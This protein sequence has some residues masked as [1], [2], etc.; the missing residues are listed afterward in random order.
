[1]LRFVIAVSLVLLLTAGTAGQ[2]DTDAETLKR[3]V[4]QLS[5]GDW[6]AREKA[7]KEL[8]LI[9]RP[10][11]EYLRHLVDNPVF[12]V[13]L[14]AKEILNHIR[15]VSVEDAVA[16]KKYLKEFNPSDGA[17][18][19]RDLV[20]KLR[21]LKNVRFYLIE[22][23]AGV[24]PQEREKIASLLACVEYHVEGRRIDKDISYTTDI[25][26]SFARDE[27]LAAQLRL[28]ALRTLSMLKDG[29]A[30]AV[31]ADI[32][33]HE[34][35]NLADQALEGLAAIRGDN[36]KENTTSNKD[37]LLKWWSEASG[38]PAYDKA[39]KHLE[40]RKKSEEKESSR[41]IPFLGVVQ[42]A[43]FPD[44][45]GAYVERPWPD[46]G[47]AKAGIEAGDIIVEFDGRPVACWGDMVHGIRRGLEGQKILLKVL[48][49]GKE[50]EL[51][52]LLSKRPE[53]Q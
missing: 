50:F 42:S 8:V 23:I 18:K 21:R 37:E 52:A 34:T 40:T 2:E 3:L 44:N 38:E 6:R 11:V 13:R 24:R 32:L 25:L 14:R 17:E 4:S 27:L 7:Q 43:A 9:G 10:A 20:I 15:V 46:S 41:E 30:A 36:K 1:M 12:E 51:E 45:G 39:V 33:K 35:G 48:R 19:V 28:R 47:A 5:E 29:D 22:K 49:N 26:L 53:D 16:I 31:L